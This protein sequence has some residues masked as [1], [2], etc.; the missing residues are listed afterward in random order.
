MPNLTTNYG[1][2]KPLANEYIKP[3]DFNYN[4]DAI[5][6]ALKT[7]SDGKLSNSGGAMTGELTVKSPAINIVGVRNIYAGTTD[8]TAG[9]SALATGVIY[10]VYE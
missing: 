10:L 2:K 9:T 5:D 7:L 1:L 4:A 8:L 6:A 3:D